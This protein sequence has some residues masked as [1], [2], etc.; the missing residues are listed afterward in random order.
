[1]LISL[2]I[3][4]SVFATP[5]HA[6]KPEI[7]IGQANGVEF[8]LPPNE[9]QIFTNIFMWTINAN[10]QMQCD[11]NEV[12]TVQFKVLKKSGSLNGES[13]KTG[14]SRTIDIHSKDEM[15]ISANPSGKV[16]LKNIGKTTIHAYCNVI[17]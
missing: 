5:S 10:C 7:Y 8:V 9:A 17:N 1:M 6:L 12:N 14:D 2:G 11:K 16:E 13:L 4:V 15:I 3:V